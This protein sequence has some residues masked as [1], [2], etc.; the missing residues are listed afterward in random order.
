M[1]LEKELQSKEVKELSRAVLKLKNEEETLAFFRDLLSLEEFEDIS[2]RWAA[3][4]MLAKEMTYEDIERKTGMSSATIS[5]VNYWMHHGMGG[6][7]LML[8]RC[9]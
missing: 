7:K 4:R 8:K 2:R 6:Y 9:S 1:E 5:R 3:A